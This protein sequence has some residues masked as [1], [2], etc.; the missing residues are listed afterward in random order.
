MQALCYEAASADAPELPVLVERFIATLE[1]NS[2]DVHLATLRLCLVNAGVA[3]FDAWHRQEP[4][5]RCDCHAYAWSDLRLFTAQSGDDPRA[6]FLAWS[7]RLSSHFLASHPR[8]AA[9]RAAALIRANPAAAWRLADL[10]GQSGARPAT[11]RR[12]FRRRYGMRP[13]AYVQLA[14]A[15]RALAACRTVTKVEA[16]AWE[17]GYRSKKDLYAAFKR[18]T[19]ATPSELR[20]LP[21]E[22]REWLIRQLRSTLAAGLPIATRITAGGGGPIDRADTRLSRRPMRHPRSA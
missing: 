12:Q 9:V 18:W 3:I 16:I 13:A 10:A 22:E 21:S 17:V 7:R 5:T 20:S 1:L 6:A 11:L 2:N 8:T 15:A 19:G 4:A 14:R